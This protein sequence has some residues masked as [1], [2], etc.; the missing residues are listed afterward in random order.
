M[1]NDN[2]ERFEN[3]FDELSVKCKWSSI[4]PLKMI[5]YPSQFTNMQIRSFLS[6]ISASKLAEY[7]DL[8]NQIESILSSAD[9]DLNSQKGISKDPAV[10][11]EQQEALKVNCRLVAMTIFRDVDDEDDDDDDD[12]DDYA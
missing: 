6:H 10:I 9:S 12:D 2:M 5:S 4:S 3:S 1:A 8:K 7:N 11:K